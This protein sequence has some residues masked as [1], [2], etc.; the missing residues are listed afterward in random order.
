MGV[1]TANQPLHLIATGDGWLVLAKHDPDDATSRVGLTAR[2]VVMSAT[3][4]SGKP[5][6]AWDDGPSVLLGMLRQLK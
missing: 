3:A 6:V 4:A 2:E 5:I 1:E